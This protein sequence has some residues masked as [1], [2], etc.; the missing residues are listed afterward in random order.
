MAMGVCSSQAGRGPLP[1]ALGLPPTLSRVITTRLRRT[2]P[3]GAPRGISRAAVGVVL[4]LGITGCDDGGGN[5]VP[6]TSAVVS[7]TER[8]DDGVLTV[9]AVLPT[10]GAA[11]EIG[12]SMTAAL[13]VATKEINDAGGVNG[14]PIRVVLR[15]EGDNSATA[16]LAVQNLVQIGVD[17]VIG[18][19]SSLN[20]LETLATT[21]EAGVLTCAPTASAMALDTYPDGGLLIRTIAS[22][23]LQATALARLVEG[24]GAGSAAVVY[25][26]DGYGRP[27]GEA[28]RAAIVGAGTTVAVMMPF[29][30]TDASLQAAAEA[31]A[32][33]D[34]D[35]VAVVADD[36]GGPAVVA[37]IDDATRGR[38]TFVV[39]DAGRRPDTA[40]PPYSA[41]LAER[42]SGVSPQA[43]SMSA[44]F[45]TALATA[46]A[47]ASGLFAQNAY[48]CLNLLAL[49]A[50]AAESSA[51]E[52]IAAQTAAVSSSGTS[53]TTFPACVAGIELGRN[54]D[55]DGPSGT[56]AIGPGGDVISA[57]FER[58]SFDENGR[59]VSSGTLLIGQ[60]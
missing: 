8:P 26:D 1:S 58:F 20:L 28:T 3:S 35:V 9:G 34:V 60:A 5:A 2:W 54:I 43:Y 15:E 6:P 10:A 55:Y 21:V 39:N 51:P 49:A 22:D 12:T 14:R 30:N 33:A 16:L 37:A 53:C 11:G 41:D 29:V 52:A 17:A 32:A 7:T 25:L 50:I 45:T 44:M 36:L 48:D 47:E 27:F 4:L 56:L 24:T 57:A 46:D 23:S 31:V 40:A 42:I 59:D 18:P 38:L 19:T 13:A